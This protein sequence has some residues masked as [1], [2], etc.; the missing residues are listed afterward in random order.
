MSST[1]KSDAAESNTRRT[2][3]S[4]RDSDLCQVAIKKTNFP[5]GMILL[6][7]E[8]QCMIMTLMKLSRPNPI[9]P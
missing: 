8:T 6:E 1:R 9:T 3:Y 2:G 7:R 5:T 4:L